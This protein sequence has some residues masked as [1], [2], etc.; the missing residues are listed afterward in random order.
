M[1]SSIFKKTAI[2]A[3]V[4][5]SLAATLPAEATVLNVSWEGAFTMLN[6][7]GAPLTNTPSDYELG[8]YA[9][10]DGNHATVGPAQY[11][12]NINTTAIPAT[13]K[14]LGTYYTGHSWYGKRTP[15]SG[16]MSFD[17]STGAGVGSV[18]DFLFFGDTPG[19]GLGTSVARA[20][21]ISFAMVDTVGTLVGTMLFSWNGGGHS[22]SIVLDASGMF[23]ALGTTGLPPTSVI[24]G[25]GALP[26][27]D[28][29]NFGTAETPLFLP[30]GPAP[31]A[32]KFE[33]TGAGCDG[34]PV[35]TQVNAYTI[36]PIGSAV[37]T[38]AGPDP[39]G[40]GPA[41]TD[42]SLLV[43]DGIGADPMT[44]GAFG[45]HN[46]NFDITWVHIDSFSTPP[47]IPV[48]AAVWLFG[49]GLLGL[50]GIARRKKNA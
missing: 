6:P 37:V 34:I 22:V 14:P 4:A 18:N 42:G 19:A 28:S 3:A 44:S 2:A 16:K 32:T 5:G 15:V 23:G 8:F 13:N 9:N 41:L 48:P 30:L 27:T 31:V 47:A 43:S 12:A 50:V 49:S 46:A 36:V 17:T 7:A 10:A 24:S 45:L 20:L 33:N 29:L 1:N 11:T 38:C 21:G 25:V 26:A 40:T 39:D 35:A